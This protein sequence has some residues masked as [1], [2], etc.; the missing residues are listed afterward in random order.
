MKKILSLLMVLV[1]IFSLVACGKGNNSD[2]ESNGEM[3]YD[4]NSA[5][6]DFGGIEY[7]KSEA[8]DDSIVDT[9]S[10]DRGFDNQSPAEER[11][12]IKSANMEVE[13]LE[14]DKAITLLQDKVNNVGGYIESSNVRGTSLYD[15]YSTKSANYTL[16]IPEERFTD[17]MMDMNTIG[18][19]ISEGT[20][21]NDI[22]ESYYDTD[23]HLKTLKIQEER[24]LDILR[25]AEIIEDVISLERELANVRYEIESLTG[26]LRRWDNLVDYATLNISI[27]EVYEITVEEEHPKTLWERISQ[28]F[29][30]SI[31]N[32]KDFFE[33]ATV[34]LLG[35]IP[36]LIFWIPGLV[37]LV[38]IIK[39]IVKI[40]K[41]KIRSRAVIRNDEETIKK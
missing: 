27:Y 35:T 11:K 9:D 36:F 2:N 4:T 17:F 8:M 18:N 29:S 37:I 34:F 1:I 25:K 21:G 28:K 19:I 12:I 32:V 22:T 5:E 13:T 41:K 23:A 33:D 30:K 40:F 24:L 7:S 10:D 16:R 26:S 14:F 15:D 20:Y 6:E 38:V 31:S 3:A 39:K